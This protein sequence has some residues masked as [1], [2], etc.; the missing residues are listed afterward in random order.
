[1]HSLKFFYSWPR[2]DW[3]IL[4]PNAGISSWFS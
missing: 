1:M 2:R 4:K 3:L